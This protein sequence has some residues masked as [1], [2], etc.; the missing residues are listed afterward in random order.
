MVLLLLI[1]LA[2][3]LWTIQGELD[4]SETRLPKVSAHCPSCHT[5]TDIDW[6]VCPHCQARLRESC[7]CCHKSKLMDHRYCP[8]CGTT[9]EK[10]AA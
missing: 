6:M 10:R 7:S 4:E 3:L 8:F 1:S 2:F 5:E 9:G